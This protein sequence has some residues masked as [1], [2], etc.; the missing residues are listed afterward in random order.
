LIG[1]EGPGS[2]L[3]LLIKEGLAL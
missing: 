3:S 2:L 1:H